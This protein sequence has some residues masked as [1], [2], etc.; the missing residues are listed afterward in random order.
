MSFQR[1]ATATATTASNATCNIRGKRADQTFNG[2]KL[3]ANDQPGLILATVKSYWCQGLAPSKTKAK[4]PLFSKIRNYG[5]LWGITGNYGGIVGKILGI[6]AS[7]ASY[8]KGNKLQKPAHRIG[9][10]LS[11]VQLEVQLRSLQDLHV[12][13][14]D[15]L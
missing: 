14:G 15:A 4:A 3:P 1:Q 12:P 8:A 10:L 9:L 13:K 5:T 6:Y 11:D 2:Q 7:Q